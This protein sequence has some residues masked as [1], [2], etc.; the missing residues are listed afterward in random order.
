M[1]NEPYHVLNSILVTLAFSIPCFNIL[2]LTYISA[3]RTGTNN[4]LLKGSIVE[5][6]ADAH[7]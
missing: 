7:F 5:A 2:I 1:D 3:N 4:A 6:A